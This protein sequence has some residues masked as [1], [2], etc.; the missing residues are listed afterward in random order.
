MDGKTGHVYNDCYFMNRQTGDVEKYVVGWNKSKKLGE[1]N[2]N[3]R[4]KRKE[5]NKNKEL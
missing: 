5:D 2:R 1:N 4:Y 3:E